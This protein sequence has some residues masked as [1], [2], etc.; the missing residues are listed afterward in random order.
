MLNKAR[1]IEVMIFEY[2]E[3]RECVREG[4]ETFYKEMNFTEAQAIPAV[5][6]E[7]EHGAGYTGAEKIC[8]YLFLAEIYKEEGLDTIKV[9]KKLSELISK[10]IKLLK[11][12]LG[13]NYLQ[14]EHDIK[15]I[16]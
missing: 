5:L 1:M 2:E 16:M 3:L 14:F 10:D 12:D 6:N 11:E 4:F 7:Y 8:I 13:E 9:N 15:K